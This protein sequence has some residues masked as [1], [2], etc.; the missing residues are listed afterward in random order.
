[1]GRPSNKDGIR[2]KARTRD[3]FY[4]VHFEEYPGHWIIT[5]EQDREKAIAWGKRNRQRLI[6]Q[7]DETMAFYCRGFFKP[8][9]YWVKKM[10]EKGHH[11][12][13]KY[14][15][16]RQG[17]LD[18]YV[19]PAFGE[20]KPQS[21]NR[22]EIDDWLL[23]LTKKK[24]A[25]L[26]GA[27]KNKIMYSFSIVFERLKDLGKI[28]VNPIEGIRPY[29]KAPVKPRGALPREFLDKLYP[30]SHGA[31][32]RIWGDSIWASMMLVF[33]DTGSRPGEVRALK[34]IDI[35]IQKRFIPIR[36]GVESGTVDKIKG[37]KTG[38]VKAG[39]LSPRTVQELE[40]WRSES[41]HNDDTDY[42]FTLTG[43]TP[44]TNEGVTKAF[45]RGLSQV[46]RENPE[47]KADPNWTPYWLR[48][49]FGTYQ[50][51]VLAEEEIALLMGNGVA[52]LKKHYQ[53]PDDETLYKSTA[54]IR[55]KLDKVRQ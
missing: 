33:N 16:T 19:I 35:D 1:M 42:V 7:R 47:W 41:R 40:I 17:H 29:N 43:K 11:F 8:D 27:T 51:E 28:D 39:F 44:V 38:T 14:L 20:R 5:P 34:W 52:V 36:Q 3:G 13:G 32:V 45:R 2:A 48:H 31:L 54:G 46:E 55:E 6:N 15:L 53:H 25:K 49:S 50:M 24:D 22:L 37:T 23:S 26:A 21:I 4:T 10:Q 30:A 18:N 12:T 9:S